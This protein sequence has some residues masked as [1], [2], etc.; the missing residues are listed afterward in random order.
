MDAIKPHPF[1][2][3]DRIIALGITR[4]EVARKSGRTLGH[5]CMSLNGQRPLSRYLTN[6]IEELLK[7]KERQREKQ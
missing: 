7:E 3:S 2:L 4:T 1:Q 6:V 5:V